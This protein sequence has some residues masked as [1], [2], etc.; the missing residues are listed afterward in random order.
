M[1]KVV[2]VG[3][4]ILGLGCSK[5]NPETGIWRN[6]GFV[7]IEEPLTRADD[8]KMFR[9]DLINS[10]GG[11]IRAVVKESGTK[12]QAQFYYCPGAIDPNADYLIVAANDSVFALDNSIEMLQLFL[13]YDCRDEKFIVLNPNGSLVA[14]GKVE[15]IKK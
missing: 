11:L 6:G 7:P 2:L 15:P 1:R 3:A 10:G 5:P 8:F 14:G 4:L 9:I 12:N 13:K